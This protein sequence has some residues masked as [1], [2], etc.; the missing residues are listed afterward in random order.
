MSKTVCI[1]KNYEI[2]SEL[3]SSVTITF[4]ISAEI[5][6]P[7][8]MAEFINY[9]KNSAQTFAEIMSSEEEAHG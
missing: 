4:E 2:R 3:H 5:R 9:M 7:E 1:L 6:T 8:L